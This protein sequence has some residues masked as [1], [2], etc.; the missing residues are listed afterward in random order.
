VPPA[1][2]VEP[3][4]PPKASLSQ[5]YSQNEGSRYGPLDPPYAPWNIDNH[6]ASDEKTWGEGAPPAYA[7][8]PLAPPK[9]SLSQKYALNYGSRY[10][11]LSPPYAPWNIDN[12]HASD[13]KTWGEHAPKDYVID[14]LKQSPPKK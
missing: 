3:L 7:V 2:A 14:D 12:H 1:Y 4:A 13:E 5:K 6:H 11:P 8:E 9:A 10:G